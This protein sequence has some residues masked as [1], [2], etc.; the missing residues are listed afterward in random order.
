MNNAPMLIEP[1][2]QPVT[3]IDNAGIIMDVNNAFLEMAGKAGKVIRK[4]DRIGHPIEAFATVPQ[5]R[6]RMIDFVRTLAA[7]ETPQSCCWDFPD[8]TGKKRTWQIEGRPFHDASGRRIGSLL[9]WAD[10]TGELRQKR[11]QACR[12]RL[13]LAF[14]QVQRNADV[15]EA[16]DTLFHELKELHPQV[17]NCSLQV[18]Q[19]DRGAWMTYALAETGVIE[20]PE[21]PRHGRAV[22]TCWREQ[23]PIYRPDVLLDDPYGEA[24]GLGKA[25]P[26]HSVLDVPFAQGTLALNSL[27]PDAFDAEEIAALAELAH[28]LSAALARLTALRSAVRYR[29]LVESPPDTVVMHRAPDGRYLYVSPQA[30]TVWGY[31]PDTFFAD[32]TSGEWIAHPDDR[33]G[34]EE[35][36]QRVATGG[37]SERRESRV[38][39][40]D[41]S[42]RWGLETLSPIHDAG[43]QIEAVQ[44]MWQDIT[45][46]K[47]TEQALKD[48][49]AR[50][51]VI[52]D[53]SGDAMLTLAPPGWRFT[54]ANPAALALF[55]V[56]TQEAFL[57]LG[58]RDLSPQKQPDGRDSSEKIR[59]KIKR[60]MREGSHFFE[61][62]HRRLD[63]H[64]FPCQVLLN[65]IQ[66]GD[67]V[68]LQGTVRDITERKR[69]EEK[70]EEARIAAEAANQSKSMFLANMSHEIRTPMNG[71]IGMIGLLLDTD[72]T[73]EQRRYAE[74]VRTSGETLLSLID[75]LLDIS[76]MEANRL[77][78]EI[79]DFDLENLVDDCMVTLALQAQEKGLE[80]AYVIDPDVP[81][82]VRG[83]PGRLRQILTNL[84]GNAVK[85]TQAG[86][87]AIRVSLAPT[88]TA[89]KCRDD[90]EVLVHFSI[91][92][93]G[94]GIP[95][96]KIGGLFDTFVQGDA[97]TTRR[98]G[99]TGLGLAISRQLVGIMGGRIGVVSE[100]GKGSEFWFS[101]RLA[102]QSEQRSVPVVRCADLGG[103]RALIVDDNA[104]NREIL[105]T[106]MASWGMRTIEVEDGQAALE[107]L[108]RAWEEQDPIQ[109]AVID[110]HMPDMDG[111]AVGRALQSDSRL[112]AIR[113]VM[114]TS[115]AMRGDVRRL[116]E[117]GFAAYLTKP[118]RSRELN[119]VLRRVLASSGD[120]TSVPD[121]TTRYTAADTRDLFAGGAMR[122]LVAEDN[123]TNQQVAVA[124]LKKMGLAAD[125]VADGNEAM[126]ALATIPYDLVLMDVQ[127]PGLD[128]LEATQRI[129]AHQAPVLDRDV[130]IIALTAHAMSGDRERCLEAGMNGYVSKP[131]DPLALA[132][133]LWK[134]L[135]GKTAAKWTSDAEI[136]PPSH[137][138]DGA[139]TNGAQKSLPAFDR[140]A[141]LERLM[142]DP[143][144]VE[145]IIQAFL[146][147]IPGQVAAL[148]EMVAQGQVEP[149]VIQAHKIKGAASNVTAPALQAV[150]FAVELAAKVQDT[151]RLNELLPELEYQVARVRDAMQDQALKHE[152]PCHPGASAPP[153]RDH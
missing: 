103:V 65:R 59:E 74:I 150:A 34:G 148:K 16:L 36:F 51:R 30:E 147:D 49:E 132:Q 116:N 92:D 113:M 40:R 117:I 100:D 108:Y 62:T 88:P 85:F 152:Y 50:H 15:P 133:E 105:N 18:W 9:L 140:T 8:S 14:R 110:M 141:L 143:E 77:D 41:G 87:V 44:V 35:A 119:A 42:Q 45:E 32:A 120:D 28:T 114:L 13:R 101:V 93:T 53:Q 118:V 31:D 86:E 17:R 71:V 149:A 146:S 23:R 84:A 73:T 104:T 5:G 95:A 98:Y 75:D 61:W 130:P 27:Q 131:I 20:L 6:H 48:S 69:S 151:D 145:T 76:K 1:L 55:G 83:D 25:A 136:G 64:P 123:T 128:G 12:E 153:R 89:A 112:A 22:E 11:Q 10:L 142:D 122:V 124:M 82:L 96:H 7:N 37:P 135:S 38:C 111:E 107:A 67:Q 21:R 24:T 134:W 91:R 138:G 144:L 115:L 29:A 46:R 72:L 33:A 58:V 52:F 127:M 19:A 57:V 97:S 66:L 70:L 106:R 4:E 80:L 129:R 90:A 102:R 54:S 137:N 99:G 26:V 56:K 121:L 125:A 2:P 60:T 126:N 109:L 78:L 68:F 43:G 139:F 39:C 3:L 81:A 63:G 94:I 47:R 79:L